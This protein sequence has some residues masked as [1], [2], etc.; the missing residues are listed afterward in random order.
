[1]APCGSQLTTRLTIGA[2]M[3]VLANP[4][5]TRL[6]AEL[7]SD[8]TAEST[9]PA[10]PHGPQQDVRAWVASVAELTQPDEIVWC[11][12]SAD[13]K[14]RLIDEMLAAGTLVRLDQQKRPGSYLARSDPDDVARVESRTFICSERE[15]DAGPTNNWVDPAAMR[16]ELEGV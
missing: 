13:E 12:G 16:A 15:E 4:R 1:P 10:A 9:A 3:S 7:V 14:Q 11:D 8:V 5:R 2:P 6:V